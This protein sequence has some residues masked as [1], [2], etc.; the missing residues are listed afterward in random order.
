MALPSVLLQ[1]QAIPT[2]HLFL[3]LISLFLIEAATAGTK[4]GEKVSAVIVILTFAQ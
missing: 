3:L 4:G 1:A 2:I